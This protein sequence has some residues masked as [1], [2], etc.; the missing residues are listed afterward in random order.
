MQNHDLN[1]RVGAVLPIRI[2]SRRQLTSLPIW[3]RSPL[4]C[5]PPGYTGYQSTDVTPPVSI[6]TA[7]VNGATITAGTPYTITG[8]ASDVGGIVAGVDISV[9]GGLTWQVATG[10]TNWSFSWTPT[11]LGTVTI[12]TRAFDDIGNLEAPG[13]NEGS[14]NTVNVIVVPGTPPTNC[15]CFI[16]N[17]PGQGPG[18]SDI[19]QNDGGRAL[20]L[21]VKFRAAFDGTI[22]GIKFYKSTTNA[23]PITVQLWT[24]DGSLIGTGT[25]TTP[26]SGWVPANFPA[27]VNISANVTYV[28]SYFS[29]TGFYAATDNGFAT[30]VVNG[31]LIGIATSDPDGPNGVY[32]YG[33]SPAF[34]VNSYHASNYWVDVIYTPTTGPDI[35]P[36]VVEFTFPTTDATGVNINSFISA[37]FSEFIDPTTVT[38]SNFELRDASNS[39][40]PATV[41]Y[42]VNART[43]TLV[44]STPPLDYS[45]VYTATVKGGSSGI[46]DLAGNAMVSDFTWS[47]TTADPPPIPPD[48]GAGGP[49]LVISSSTN[50]FSRY[51]VEILRAQGYT[52]FKAVDITEVRNNSVNIND[53]DVILLGNFNNITTADVTLLTAWTNAGGTLIAQRPSSLLL[54]LMGV[55]ANISPTH[56]QY[57]KVN[58]TAGQPGAGI[59]NQTIQFHGTMDHYTMLAGTT[60][61]ATLYQDANTNTIFP[62]VTSVNVGLGKAI[63]FAFDLA[64]SIVFTRQ[65]DPT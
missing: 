49:L 8:T 63:A 15:P 47:F 29:P 17:T 60:A 64:N 11:V 33:G 44:P 23:S 53:Y 12:K 31:A 36:P 40:I 4:H 39:L 20:N 42:S 38:N 46:K 5:N 41:T 30:A 55:T 25:L 56:D 45:A 35:T 48:E 26:A 43:I 10:T 51:L 19:N 61:L 65:G 18:P 59:V 6:I 37:T 21:G 2:C 57:L 34:P 7:P 1:N 52:A 24:L 22:S 54:P 62:A 32:I 9:D 13:G 14:S 16:F 50:P 28:A 58:T 3:V 27:P